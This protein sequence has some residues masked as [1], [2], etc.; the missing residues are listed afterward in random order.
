MRFKVSM[1]GLSHNYSETYDK[2]GGEAGWFMRRDMR[3]G[4]S[5]GR[6]YYTADGRV[7]LRWGRC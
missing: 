2:S 4:G 3:V 5:T 1:V 7:V 6:M